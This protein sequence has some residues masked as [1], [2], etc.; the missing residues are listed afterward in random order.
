MLTLYLVSAVAAGVLILLSLFGAEHGHEA[1]VGMDH[2]H[3]GEHL[4]TWLPFLSLRF[5]TYF[6]AG[7]GTTGLLLHYLTETSSAVTLTLSLVVGFF[8]GCSVW[9]LVKILRRTESDSST[10]EGDFL[11]KEAVVLV[12]ISGRTPGRIRLTAKGDIL[13][14][15]AVSEENEPIAPGQSVVVVAMD[16]GRAQVIPRAAIFGDDALP[17]RNA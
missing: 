6:F 13:D 12:T 9:L 15:L 3:D 8:A 14:V 17:Q 4:S 11:G 1:G 5:Y 2:D 10:H 7:L 16:N